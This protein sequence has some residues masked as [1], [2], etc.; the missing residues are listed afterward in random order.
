M[1]LSEVSTSSFGGDGAKTD[2][3]EPS[4]YEREESS[5]DVGEGAASVDSAAGTAKGHSGVSRDGKRFFT[6]AASTAFTMPSFHTAS[7]GRSFPALA[8]AF[9]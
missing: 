7:V 3:A 1:F 2:T 5:D 6:L 4:R 9:N 8:N